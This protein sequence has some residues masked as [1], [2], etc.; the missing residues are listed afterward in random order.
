MTPLIFWAFFIF[1]ILTEN[2]RTGLYTRR[3]RRK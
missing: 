3:L 1:Y 2:R